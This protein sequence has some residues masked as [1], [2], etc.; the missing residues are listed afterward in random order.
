VI[1]MIKETVSIDEVIGLLNELIEIDKPAIAAIIANRVPCNQVM[2][3]HPT[4]QVGAQNGGFHV[5]MLGI[6]NGIFGADDKGWGAI[7]FE[8]DD[9]G[10]LNRVVRRDV[11]YEWIAESETVPGY[12]ASDDSGGHTHDAKDSLRFVTEIE[13]RSLCNVANSSAHNSQY[14]IVFKPVRHGFA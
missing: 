4:V 5:G 2:A 13:C 14:L 1:D 11:K 6:L 10:N 9:D 7:A 3:D 12:Y 8:F